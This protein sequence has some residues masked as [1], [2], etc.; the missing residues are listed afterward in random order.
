VDERKL[1]RLAE[2][3]A[4]EQLPDGTWKLE[5][6]NAPEFFG[7]IQG[8]VRHAA[9]KSDPYDPEDAEG[10]IME[11]VWKALQRYGPNYRQ[12]PFMNLFR[13]KVNNIL[14]NRHK[15]RQS[16]K[17][18]LNFNS[19]NC[20]VKSLEGLVAE[21]AEGNIR[22]LAKLPKVGPVDLCSLRESL[23]DS[24]YAKICKVC[25]ETSGENTMPQKLS[26]KDILH[27]VRRLSNEEKGELCIELWAMMSQI[28]PRNLRRSLVPLAAMI[29]SLNKRKTKRAQEYNDQSGNN[30]SEVAKTSRR[31]RVEFAD[32][33]EGNS[34][35]TE[36]AKQATDVNR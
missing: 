19:K 4:S 3:I 10:D 21:D 7:M 17:N 36:M 1:Q 18:R 6:K 26:V 29:T 2:S 20:V 8:Y 35:E 31:F 22:G 32:N 12:Q 25:D 16:F 13:I 5:H 9:R 33:S 11:N 28:S 24:E 23:S 27:Y 14:T 30:V 34:K 15:K